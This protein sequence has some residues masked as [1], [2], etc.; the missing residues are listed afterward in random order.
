M[1]T[2]DSNTLEITVMQDALRDLQISVASDKQEKKMLACEISK[3]QQESLTAAFLEEERKIRLDGQD[4]VAWKAKTEEEKRKMLS[5]L[6][7]TWYEDE[8]KTIDVFLTRERPNN[9]SW[10]KLTFQNVWEKFH[11]KTKLK[12]HRD[13][14]TPLGNKT[15][16]S[17]RLTPM[18]FYHTKKR[19]MEAAFQ[20]GGHRLQQ[21]PLQQG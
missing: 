16:F 5:N 15:F 10:V 7:T 6:L 1:P 12:K 18:E 19:L 4:P 20:Q 13:E 2:T 14:Q 3:V 17:S 21:H 8:A 11:F 9:P